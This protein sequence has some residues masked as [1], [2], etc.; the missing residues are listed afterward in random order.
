ML[1]ALEIPEREGDRGVVGGGG[2]V[3]H[4]EIQ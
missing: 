2:G 3:G 4:T 1:P